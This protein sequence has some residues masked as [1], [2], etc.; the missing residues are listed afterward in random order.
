MHPLTALQTEYSVW[1]REPEQEILPVVRELGIGF[2]AYAPIGRGFLAGRF[3]DPAELMAGDVRRNH[4]RFRD[5]N[6]QANAAA[7]GQVPG[8]RRGPAD[9]AGPAGPGLAA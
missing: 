7:G 4:P 3:A 2:V 1:S 8:H 9:H 5:G 6:L